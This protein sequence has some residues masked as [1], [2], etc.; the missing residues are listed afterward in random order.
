MRKMVALSIV[1]IMFATQIGIA[2]AAMDG[3]PRK[4]RFL[5]RQECRPCHMENPIHEQQEYH[6]H[7]LGPDAKRQAEWMEV[8]E[9]IDELPCFEH[10]KE[11]SDSDINDIFTYLYNG[12]ADSPTPERCG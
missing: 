11:I 5:F 4:G 6:A 3:N 1:A 12:A 8:L 9:N 7:Y 10:W 2:L